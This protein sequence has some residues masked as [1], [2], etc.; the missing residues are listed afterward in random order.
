MNVSA[1]ENLQDGWQNFPEDLPR[2]PKMA[3][4]RKQEQ[5][6]SVRLENN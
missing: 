6:H 1:W 2:T 4:Q 3:S 5:Q